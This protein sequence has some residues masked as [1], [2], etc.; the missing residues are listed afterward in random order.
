MSGEVEGAPG[1]SR[2]ALVFGG[3]GVVGREV[4]RLLSRRGVRTT[5]TYHRSIEEA[6]ALSLELGQRAEPLDLADS[7]AIKALFATLREESALPDVFLHC[8]ATLGSGPDERG[9]AH[10]RQRPLGVRRLP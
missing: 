2:R 1:S 9:R 10:G 7:S 4:L 6:R 5:F 3:T 8:A